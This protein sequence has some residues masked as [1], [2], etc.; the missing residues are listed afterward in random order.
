MV[1]GTASSVGKSAIAA[2][3]CRIL[4]RRGARVAPF[5]A[6]NMSLNAAV[7]HD[8]GEIGRST[9]V[10]AAAAGVEPTV[11]MNPILLKPEA[12]S[13][14]Q[15]IVRGK[16]WGT[17]HARDY[18]QSK[19]DFWPIVVDALDR[20]RAT[21]DVVV[22][23]GA[24]SPAE[25]NLRDR[26]IVNMRVAR[27]GD[28]AVVLVGDIDRGGVFAQLIGTLDLLPPEERQLV[29]GLIVNRFRGDRSL[30][31]DGV[32]FLEE[33]TACPVFGV[34]P[35]VRDLALAEEDSATLD[36]R[37]PP[38]HC[39]MT[40][41]AFHV[42][43]VQ[44]PRIANFDDFGPLERLAGVRVS[45][46]DRPDQL[47]DADLVIVPGSK[48]TIADLTW[49][50]ERGLDRA[51]GVAHVDGVPI[52]GICGGY[53]ML[54]SFIADPERVEA[55]SGGAPGL[56]LLP[57]R[58]VFRR[59]KQTSRVRARLTGLTGPF[60]A[61]QGVEVEGYE[62]HAGH[63]SL[64]ADAPGTAVPFRIVE[65]SEAPVDD[66]EGVVTA[67]GLLFGTYLHGLFDN[68]PIQQALV[69]W[70]T[71]RAV[72]KRGEP[73]VRQAP[74]LSPSL[75][76]SPALGSTAPDPYDRW[77]DVLEDALD[78]PL[79]LERCGLAAYRGS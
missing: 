68:I 75:A 59:D 25:M 78:L 54:G 30:F 76:R 6:Q 42:V 72:S 21:H 61:I 20:L 15:V 24:G 3:F 32:R 8:G 34:V 56:G 55:C 4:R 10:Q 14:S 13:S 79:L 16:V 22:A 45:Y 71:E 31:A 1:Q 11:D 50:R 40:H 39:Q 66:P 47:T 44:L 26:D 41:A 35:A 60:A 58:T 46:V 63:T 28:A 18:F 52:F 67:D 69:G 9:A 48:S 73:R 53:Q 7:T 27:Y 43:V 37:R 2:G 64:D 17:L 51:L 65:R 77:A 29:R 38:D 12:E 19:L 62:I 74:A 5:K 33:R 23:E 57:N 36:I 70:L 49:L